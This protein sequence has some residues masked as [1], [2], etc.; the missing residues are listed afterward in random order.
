MPSSDP[1]IR[2]GRTF[3]HQHLL[4]TDWTPGPGQK[5]ADAPKAV[6]HVT[7]V[8]TRV[9]REPDVYY[10]IGAEVTRGRFVAS[11]PRFLAGVLGEWL[12]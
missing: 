8:R 12:T 10:A 11:A 5:Y 4:D 7:A 3:R 6:C 2:V 1:I 9:G